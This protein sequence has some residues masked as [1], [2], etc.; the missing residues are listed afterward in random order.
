MRRVKYTPSWVSPA[1]VQRWV[2][3]H[4][5]CTGSSR[6]SVHA[7]CT[8][9]MR[10][11]G[12]PVAQGSIT[13]LPARPPRWPLRAHACRARC[14]ALML[15]P[16]SAKHPKRREPAHPW[17]GTC[18]QA[19]RIRILF[20]RLTS[21]LNTLLPHPIPSSRARDAVDAVPLVPAIGVKVH[22]ARV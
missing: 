20:L 21:L 19:L 10:I 1:H 18:R 8:Y 9:P 22:R 15:S 11:G 5:K 4:Y 3:S 17:P 12:V 2:G 14:C 6:P 7:H 13:R 16:S